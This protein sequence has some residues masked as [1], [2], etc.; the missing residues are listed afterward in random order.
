MAVLASTT[1]AAA[2]DKQTAAAAYSTHKKS[3]SNCHSGLAQIGCC[4]IFEYFSLFLCFG[5]EQIKLLFSLLLLWCC[6]CLANVTASPNI[7]SKNTPESWKSCKQF[8]VSI[9]SPPRAKS[10]KNISSYSR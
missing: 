4:R 5:S 1:A 6:L 9:N 3:P 2:D 8:P 10:I 7:Y